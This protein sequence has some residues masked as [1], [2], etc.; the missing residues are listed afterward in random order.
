MAGFAA[1]WKHV[2][3]CKDDKI[4]IRI[5]KAT[6]DIPWSERPVEPCGKNRQDVADT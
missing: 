3:E 1:F 6:V 5:L 4:E 2:A